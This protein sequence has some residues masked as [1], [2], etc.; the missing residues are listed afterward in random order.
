MLTSNEAGN[1]KLRWELIKYS[2]AESFSLVCN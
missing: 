1:Q 2:I